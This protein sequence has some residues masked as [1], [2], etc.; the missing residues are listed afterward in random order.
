MMIR[1]ANLLAEARR[2]PGMA[3]ASTVDADWAPV[4]VRIREEATDH[5]DD[6][7]AVDRF[8]ELGGHFVRGRGRITGRGEVTVDTDWGPRVFWARRGILVNTGTEPAIPPVIGLA[9]TPYW[10]NREAI[11]AE[12]VPQSLIVLGGGAVGAELAQAFARFGT[13]VIVVEARERLLPMDEPEAG[14]LLA[15][16]FTREGIAVRTGAL[17]ERV[18]HDGHRFA[19]DLAGGE[20]VTGQRL[21]VATRDQPVIT[22]GALWL[23]VLGRLCAGVVC[24]GR[25]AGPQRLALCVPRPR[26]RAGASASSMIVTSMSA[27]GPVPVAPTHLW[28][29][30][31]PALLAPA[32]S[33]GVRQPEDVTAG[34]GNGEHWERVGGVQQCHFGHALL[35]LARFLTLPGAAAV[36]RPL[37]VPAAEPALWVG[38]GVAGCM[39]HRDG[40][41]EPQDA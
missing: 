39:Y 4:A 28:P 9:A 26:R 8:R 36:T 37:G 7:V 32:A 40:V 23:Q 30:I 38:A 3:G 12:Q 19:M 14:D 15:G 33:Q 13:K 22:L 27:R 18:S 29:P 20:T 41:G 24:C 6:K 11:E 25:M 5:W 10:T 31:S 34:K 1:A 17:A 2:V 21:L 16:V 35:A